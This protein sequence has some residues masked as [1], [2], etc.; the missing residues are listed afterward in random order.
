MSR[1]LVLCCARMQRGE[2]AEWQAGKQVRGE[3]G[4]QGRQASRQTSRGWHQGCAPSLSLSLCPSPS[5][6]LSPSRSVSLSLS[7]RSKRALSL[8]LAFALSCWLSLAGRRPL[9]RARARSLFRSRAL[10]FS[11]ALLLSCAHS[12]A[13]TPSHSHSHTF[14]LVLT[15]YSGQDM[16]LK[17]QNLSLDDDGDE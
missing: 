16:L 6:S 15:L 2:E 3:R 1:P 11:L 14:S 5:R 8:P 9:F 17:A 12:S 13:L 4:G 7:R 10:V